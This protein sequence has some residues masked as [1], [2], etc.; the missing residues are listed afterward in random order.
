MEIGLLIPLAAPYATREFVAALG[1]AAEEA[2]FSSLW[3][4]EHLV[5]D[6]AGVAADTSAVLGNGVF[7]NSG[8][9]GLATDASI[10][11]P[12]MA[13][14]N[15]AG[16]L[17]VVT[18]S[19]HH[20]V[21]AVNLAGVAQLF[22]GVT[23]DPGEVEVVTAKMR[24]ATTGATMRGQLDA[25]RGLLPKSMQFAS[26]VEAIKAEEVDRLFRGLLVNVFAGYGGRRA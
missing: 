15:P 16:N 5:C 8:D 10:G 9:G 12:F 13:S 3:V 26:T 6:S 23:I 17:V 2:G 11:G 25:R 20:R 14:L 24:R 22:L 19:E 7:G 21:R 1:V 18:D 4:G